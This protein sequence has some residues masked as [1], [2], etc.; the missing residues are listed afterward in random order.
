MR[1]L[2][3]TFEGGEGSGKS[4]QIERLAAHLR[5]EGLDP[6]A[7]REPGGTPLGERVRDV[8]LDHELSPAPL[9]EALLMEAARAEIVA[10]VIAP[11]LEAGRIVL[12]D[13]YVH[14]TLAYQGGGRGLDAALLEQL[15]RTATGGLAPDLVVLFDVAPEIGLERRER[16]GGSPNRLDRES[17]EFHRR[18]RERYLDLARREPDRFFVLDASLPPDDQERRIWDAVFPR[19]GTGRRPAGA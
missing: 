16:A 2:F 8:L 19:V 4:T 5:A 7:T 1:G 13:R 17:P 14:S 6:L 15:N 3:V 12:C 9:T 10:R 18:V 11:A